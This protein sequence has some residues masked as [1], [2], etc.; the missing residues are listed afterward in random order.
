MGRKPP[1]SSAIRQ[2]DCE[3]VETE[4]TLANSIYSRPAVQDHQMPFVFMGAES[5]RTLCDVMRT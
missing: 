1:E 2:Q 5:R 3:V 4:G